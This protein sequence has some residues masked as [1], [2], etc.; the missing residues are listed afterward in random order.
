MI[1]L[2]W[3]EIFQGMAVIIALAAL[4]Y[5][6]WQNKRRAEQQK[7]QNYLHGMSEYLDLAKIMIERPEL[8]SIY[9]Y[10]SQDLDRSYHC[11]SSEE[12]ARVYYCNT[13]IALF[14][15][16]WVANKKG[17]LS[18]DEWPYWLAWARQLNQSAEFR[19]TLEWVKGDYDGDFLQEIENSQVTIKEPINP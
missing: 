16:V 8:H 6:A 4:L 19:W 10:S 12:K 14:E 2:S 13:I 1:M 15:T 18:K 3:T 11:L 5:S 7:F 17:W 9:D